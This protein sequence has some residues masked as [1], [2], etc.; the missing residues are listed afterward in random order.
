[1][2]G[3]SRADAVEICRSAGWVWR[4]DASNADTTRMRAALRTRVVPL[5]RELSPSLT[6]RAGAA[7]ELLADAAGLVRDRA[8]ELEAKGRVGAEGEEWER[9]T[10]ASERSVV[11]G[12]VLRRA[13]SRACR[14][15]RTDRRPARSL[16]R[17]AALIRGEVHNRKVFQLGGAEVVV[18]GTRVVVRGRP[19][20]QAG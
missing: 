14:G 4:E 7:G 9:S 6:V 17:I 12:E 15:L 19:G 16:L 8:A 3:Q 18:T 5:L 1:M 20:D 2:L 11:V 10:L 13:M